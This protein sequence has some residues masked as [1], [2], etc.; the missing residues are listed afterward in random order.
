MLALWT[1]A[2]Y[3]RP[4]EAPSTAPPVS[5]AMLDL[6][7]LPGRPK[8]EAHTPTD[9]KKEAPLPDIHVV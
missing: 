3:Y 2:L 5:E 6:Q 7:E 1:L 9:E 4:V 8:I